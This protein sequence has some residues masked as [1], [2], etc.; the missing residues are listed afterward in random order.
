MEA[1]P[2]PPRGRR[3]SPGP[4]GALS[5]VGGAGG[6]QSARTAATM[7]WVDLTDEDMF[8]HHSPS[9]LAWVGRRYR[10]RKWK[11]DVQLAVSPGDLGTGTSSRERG[12]GH[13]KAVSRGNHVAVAWA[14]LPGTFEV[15]R[16]SQG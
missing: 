9:M 6:I 10:E 4:R 15:L 8:S 7:A 16:S 1:S 14:G 13:A 11:A 2:P 3:R 12:Q 5:W